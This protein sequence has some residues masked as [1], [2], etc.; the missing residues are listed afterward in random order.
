MTTIPRGEASYTRD[1][2]AALGDT[3]TEERLCDLVSLLT[4]HGRMTY[5]EIL[6]ADP[7]WVFRFAKYTA[8][9]IRPPE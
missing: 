2:I 7:R 3:M 5:T 8:N 6:D 1:L 9:R 4:I